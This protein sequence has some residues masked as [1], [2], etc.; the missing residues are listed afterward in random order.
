MAAQS[1]KPELVY[2]RSFQTNTYQAVVQLFPF[3][4]GCYLPDR[5]LPVRNPEPSVRTSFFPGMRIISGSLKGRNI[6]PP[7]SFK[8]RPTTDFAKEGLF[9]VLEHSLDFN[10]TTVLDLFAGSGGISLEF[11]SRGCLSVTCVE[12]NSQHA[13]FIKETVAA[14]GLA[15]SIQVVRNNV[16]DFLKICTRKYS[17]VFADPPYD[18]SGL[19]NLPE[20]ILNAGILEENGMLVLEHPAAFSFSGSEHFVNEKKYGNVHFSFFA[21]SK[22]LPT[23]ALPNNQGPVVQ[24]G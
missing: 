16:F 21:V 22:T 10:T 2:K 11:A 23:F 3:G 14:L 20:K 12:M 8:A 7:K 1:R 17:L 13:A 15:S 5:P 24:P 6:L 18:L 19:E 9:N 4:D